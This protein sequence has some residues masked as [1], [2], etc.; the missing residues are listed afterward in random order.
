MLK[1]I[2]LNMETNKHY[3][4]ILPFIKKENPDVIC[5]QEAPESFA[6]EL[7][8]KG[9]KTFFAPMFLRD[10]LGGNEL[11]TLGIMLASK[12]PF[13]AKSV[14]YHKPNEKIILHDRK[15]RNN[16]VATAYI[17]ANIM[18]SDGL[19]NVATTH[20]LKSDDGKANDFQTKMFS[21]LLK[22]LAPEE[23]HMICGDFNM[24]RGYNTIYEEVTKKYTDAVPLSYKSSLDRD[25]H[26]LGNKKTDVPIFD[27]YMVDYVFTQPPYQ[28]ENVRLEFGLS[29]HAAVI[30]TVTKR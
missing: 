27:I 10:D 7:Q 22:L 30:A 9:Y 19:Y 29:D 3:T 28:A 16:T 2:S 14:Y 4:K 24:P 26:L 21:S 17:F 5:L 20:P 25:I 18:T 8:K 12:L 23:P 15:N 11:Y 1:I 6:E 13:Q